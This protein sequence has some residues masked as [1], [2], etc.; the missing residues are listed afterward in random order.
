MYCD[1]EINEGTLSLTAFTLE[2]TPDVVYVVATIHSE[3]TYVRTRWEHKLA[4]RVWLT[5]I[6]VW[7]RALTGK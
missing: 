7:L 4:E 5:L 2:A 6:D 1:F 3:R